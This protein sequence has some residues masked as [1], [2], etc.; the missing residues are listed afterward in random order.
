MDKN[1]K[2]ILIIVTRGEVGGAQAFVFNLAQGLKR[3]EFN[4]TVGFG[5]GDNLKQELS[6][7][8]IGFVN[9]KHLRRTHNPFKNLFFIWE[10]YKFCSRKKFDIIH[11]NSSNSLAGALGA[12]LS[13]NKPK[14]I[15][16]AHGLSMLDKNYKIRPLLETVYYL[17][18][19]FFFLFVDRVVFVSKKNMERAKNIKLVK[20][21]DVAFNGLD[22]NDLNFLNRKDARD[23]L[24]DLLSIK[25]SNDD[26]LVG[27]IGRLAYQKNYEFLINNF[28]GI[29][30]DHPGTRLI[31]I[32]D[33]P[34]R[35]KYEKLIKKYSLEEDVYLAGEIS[36]AS[37]YLKAFD[38]FVLPSFYEGLSITLIE[39]LFAKVP[40]L[41]S[42]VG[43]NKEVV[44]N[45]QCLYRLNNKKEFLEKINN[46][47]KNKNNFVCN[48]DFMSNF[49]SERMV[50]AYKRIYFDE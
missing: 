33:G 38:I 36:G 39:A 22:N 32:G 29:K 5:E 3:S 27:S 47:L 6:K 4:V 21:G 23:F 9:F 48:N 30:K 24:A 1:K 17:F 37:K 28:S 25:I 34:K 49:E 20:K 35:K 16:T 26:L 50:E 2:E 14:I 19:K 15:F 13:K 11:F 7:S 31:I 43:G 42:D 10:L 12:K 41:V 8:G 18:F 40:M 46:V 44:P 45:K